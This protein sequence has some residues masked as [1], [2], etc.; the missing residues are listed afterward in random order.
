MLFKLIKRLFGPKR[1]LY[2]EDG[3][4]KTEIDLLFEDE[5]IEIERKN[6]ENI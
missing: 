6:D 3:C 2:F 4:P 5:N 1:E